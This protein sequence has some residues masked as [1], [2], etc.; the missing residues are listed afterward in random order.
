MQ[1]MLVTP[2]H[3]LRQET[4]ICIRDVYENVHGANIDA[5]PRT[6]IAAI[7]GLGV[8]VC[9]AGLR[10]AECGF[11]SESYLDDPID[12]LLS[13]RTGRDTA[14]ERI[15]E[16]T[17]LASRKAS[18]AL[19]FVREIVEFGQTARFEWAFFTATTRLRALLTYMGLPFEVL[20]R[21]DPNRIPHPER[22]GNYY[23][24]GPRVCAVDSRRLEMRQ[25]EA[26]LHYAHA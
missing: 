18:A 21:A 11:F 15:F 16:V 10:F 4:E 20:G 3:E 25:P 24:C 19:P 9:A 6:L 8:P 2:H 14:R 7:D 26:E 5:F 17:T 13:R 23:S 1:I 12:R 22:W